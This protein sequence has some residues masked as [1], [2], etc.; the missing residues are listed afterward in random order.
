MP[1]KLYLKTPILTQL[2]G[3]SDLKSQGWRWK[4][5]RF[6]PIPHTSDKYETD[7][8]VV[9]ITIP[10][11]NK[12]PYKHCQTCNVTFLFNVR[13]LGIYLVVHMNNQ[14]NLN[15]MNNYVSGGSLC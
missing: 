9:A 11:C 13:R 14:L 12:I 7:V 5:R 10:S 15:K 4:I 2:N 1:N 8:V 6:N 3:H